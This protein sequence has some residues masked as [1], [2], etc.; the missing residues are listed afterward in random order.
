MKRQT[1]DQL[2]E[3]GQDVAQILEND[4]ASSKIDQDQEELTQR[5]DSLVQKLEDYSNQVPNK[6]LLLFS[7][8]DVCMYANLIDAVQMNY[9]H[10]AREVGE[11][12]FTWAGLNLLTNLVCIFWSSKPQV[13]NLISTITPFSHRLSFIF[14]MSKAGLPCIISQCKCL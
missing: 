10:Q 8:L 7:C 4:R 9:W 5:W 13:V 6:A 2:N 12:S 1:L 11:Y 14:L 3:L